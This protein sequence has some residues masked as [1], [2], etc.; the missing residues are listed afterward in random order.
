MRAAYGKRQFH[1]MPIV[2]YVFSDSFSNW[3]LIFGKLLE[4]RSRLYR[5]KFLHVNALYEIYN[6]SAPWDSNLKTKKNASGTAPHSKI[7][8]N[9]VKHFSHFE[10][11]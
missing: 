3:W 1:N 11:L 9:F 2:C 7:R 10:I 5:R 4:A 8:L 6:T